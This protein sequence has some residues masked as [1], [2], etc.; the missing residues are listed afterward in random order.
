[1]ET[2]SQWLAEAL[3]DFGRSCKQRLDGTGEAEAAIR[4]PLEALLQTA[5]TEFGLTMVPHGEAA[6][7]D[8]KVRPDYAIRVNGAIAGYVE[9]KKPRTDIDP[10]SFTGHN[11]RQWERLRDLPNLVYTNGRDWALYRHG[12]LV[13]EV[14]RLDGNLYTAGAKLAA[15]DGSFERLLRDFLG[16]KPTPIRSVEQLVRAVA[17]LCLLLR[18]EV[19]DQLARE[20]D[21]IRAG[22]PEDEQPFTGLASDWRTLLFPTASDDTFAD[23][24]AQAVTFALLLARSEDIT[25]DGR[26]LHEVGDKLGAGH[27]LMGKALQ[28]LTDNV[29][30]TFRVSLDLLVRVIGAVQWE[31][32][33]QADTD[34]Y[35]HLYERFL[36]V[37]DEQLR[38]ASGSY[39]TPHEVVSHMVRLVD[40]ALRSRLGCERGFLSPEVLTVDPAMGTGTY[41][42]G[43][44]NHVAKQVEQ[45]DGPGAVPQAVGEVAK[46]LVGFELQVG[47][48][49]VAELRA[50]DMLRRQG[51]QIPTE[52][53]QLYVTDTLDDPHQEETQLAVFAALSRSRRRANKIKA[54]TP[55]TVV[56]G[57]PP[58]KERAEGAGGWIE[59]KHKTPGSKAPL[60]DFRLPGN[61]RLEYVLKNLYIY[62]WRWATY[63]VFDAHTDHRHG[64][65]HFITTSG[66]LRGPG[67][68]GMREYLRRTCDEGWIINVSPEGMQPDVPTR[69][70]PGVQQPLAIALFVRSKETDDTTPARIHYA[71]VRGRRDDKYEQLGKLTLDGDGWRDARTAWTAPFT[72]AADSD[73]DEYPALGDL[74]PWVAPG[75]KPNR[76]W[77]YSPSPEVLRE[78]WGRLVAETD[79]E[80]KKVLFKESRD[81]KIDTHVG[82]LPGGHEHVGTIRE[83]SGACPEPVRVAYRSFDRQWVI[84]DNRLFHGPSPDLWRAVRSEQIFV[85]EQH[86]HE[87]RSGPGVVFAALVLDMH[88]FNGRG[89]RVLPMLHADGSPNIAPRLLAL[90]STRLGI[91]V[92]APKFVA[93]LAG[94]VAHSGFTQR[95]TDE[96]TTPG[97]RVPLTTDPELWAQAVDLGQE[98]IWASTY[99][100]ALSDAAVGRPKSDIRY[101]TADPRR[102]QNLKPVAATPL[103]DDIRYD[104]AT[105]TLHVGN[106]TFGPVPE[107]VWSYDVGGMPVLKKW[108]SYRK[109]QP[110]GKKTSPLDDIHAERWP[111]DW[112]RELNDLLTVL[113][114]L[115]EL[116]PRQ[117]D[118]LER[119]VSSPQLT[120]TELTKQGILPVPKAAGKARKAV[121]GALLD[122][123][124]A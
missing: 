100:Q 54:K 18:H 23:G 51:A 45:E 79:I 113:R 118:L 52:G 29:T 62:F 94:V 71:E 44:L 78:R 61:G 11:R 16:W 65:V 98:V 2:A 80:R 9:V 13:G 112:T 50:A 106:G 26:N 111:H 102:P 48:Y 69:V 95:F 49:A 55:V 97:I 56:I 64:V 21:A 70:F 73:W 77:V 24:Y 63:K 66:Y 30:E 57:N 8:L 114:R 120:V 53:L 58:Y 60:D 27:S 99:G 19:T 39:Y 22:Q 115:T 17:P 15:R 36:D 38:K 96:L 3:A 89:G 10:E 74:M 110:G 14:V 43:I 117:A 88:Y 6:L 90:L 33:R 116:E 25:L 32:I 4:P 124:D 12:E 83:E 119:I 109:A 37:Y 87:I 59:Q 5:S 31:H 75:V 107:A 35:L 122:F 67:F 72:P 46:R 20:A 40:E 85:V 104:A 76:G 34:T 42:H 68:K 123:G 84:P 82:P 105:E 47:P 81:R 28:L 41:L 1:M 86:A 103:P 93:Y 92:T 108:F 121:A 101:P 7:A 91:T